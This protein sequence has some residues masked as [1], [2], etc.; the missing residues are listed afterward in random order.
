MS[1]TRGSQLCVRFYSHTGSFTEIQGVC[2]RISNTGHSTSITL[3]HLV[4]S[5]PV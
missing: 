5:N 1:L 4:D 2:V 3:K